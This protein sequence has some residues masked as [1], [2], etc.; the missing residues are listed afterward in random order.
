[1][2]RKSPLYVVSGFLGSGKTTLINRLL[3]GMTGKRIGIIVYD[4]GPLAVDS[5]LIAGALEGAQK[6]GIEIKELNNGQLF[7]DCLVGSFIDAVAAFAGTDLDALWVEASGLAKPSP[8]V[9]TMAL[10]KK[11]RAE[12]PLISREWSAS[13]MPPGSCF[14]HPW[15]MRSRSRSRIRVSS[16]STRPTLSPIQS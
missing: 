8:L 3:S 14:W 15:S 9:D 2:N 7:C 11:K 16:S 1:M 10:I 4:F 6:T 5:S 13:G 12:T